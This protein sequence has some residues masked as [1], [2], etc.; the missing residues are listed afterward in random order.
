MQRP[1]LRKTWVPPVTP[2]SRHG[3]TGSPWSGSI[4]LPLG[5]ETEPTFTRSPVRM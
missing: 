2:A 1:V 4:R 3:S 5:S